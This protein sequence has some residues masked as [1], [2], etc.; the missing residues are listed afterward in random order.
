MR[1]QVAKLAEKLVQVPTPLMPYSLMQMLNQVPS[2]QSIDDLW[3]ELPRSKSDKRKHR[4]RESDEEIPADLTREEKRQ[5]KK[6]RKASRKVKQMEV[7]E[8]SKYENLVK[9][10]VKTMDDL[11][12]RGHHYCPCEGEKKSY[13]LIMAKISPRAPIRAVVFVTIRGVDREVIQCLSGKKLKCSLDQVKATEGLTD[14]GPHY[15]SSW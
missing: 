15:G 12:G 9:F 13:K 6:P 4:T 7:K 14:H 1:T 11:T 10:E 3:G 5:E 8:D 2:T